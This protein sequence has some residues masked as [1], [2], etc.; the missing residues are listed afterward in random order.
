[1]LKWWWWW[2]VI[3]RRTYVEDLIGV[4]LLNCIRLQEI[5]G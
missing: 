3:N 2:K 1:M 5:V 4:Y